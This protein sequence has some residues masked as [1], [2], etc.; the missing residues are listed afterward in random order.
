MGNDNYFIFECHKDEEFKL[1]EFH[2]NYLKYIQF[3]IRSSKIHGFLIKKYTV[4]R[5]E[6]SNSG[7]KGLQLIVY[8]GDPFVMYL[9]SEKSPTMQAYGTMNSKHYVKRKPK[10]TRKKRKNVIKE[11]MSIANLI[12]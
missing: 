8:S 12:N 6:L 10:L 3:T 2:E 9:K 4:T 5:K 11:T 7:L 1:K